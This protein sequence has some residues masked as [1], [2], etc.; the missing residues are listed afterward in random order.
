MGRSRFWRILIVTVT[1]LL[2]LLLMRVAAVKWRAVGDVRPPRD[3]PMRQE[4][5]RWMREDLADP[6]AIVITC[7]NVRR[8]IFATGSWLEV[9]IDESNQPPGTLSRYRI[10]FNS[11]GKI[12]AAKRMALH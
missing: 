3:S 1:L 7:S 8:Q 11:S 9:V 2:A 5:Q 6:G 12:I 4:I 10:D